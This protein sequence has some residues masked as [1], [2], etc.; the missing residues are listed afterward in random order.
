MLS[1]GRANLQ[2]GAHSVDAG[3]QD[4]LSVTFEFKKPAKGSEATQ[5]L[6]AEGRPSLFPNQIFSFSGDINVDTGGGIGLF[7]RTASLRETFSCF[8]LPEIESDLQLEELS[9][10]C[11]YKDNITGTKS[12][13]LRDV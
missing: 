5:D 12:K 7:N 3:Y 8:R 1:H 13:I 4:G 11:A 2:L 6:G 10:N 9:S